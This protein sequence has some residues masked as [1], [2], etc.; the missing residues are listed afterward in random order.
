[1]HLPRIEVVVDLENMS[2]PCCRGELH[3]IGEG[4]SERLDMVPTQFVPRTGDMQI[5]L[6]DPNGVGVEL[7]F[8]KT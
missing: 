1:V 3:R 8:P 6:Y 7:N 5:F 4:R 2:C